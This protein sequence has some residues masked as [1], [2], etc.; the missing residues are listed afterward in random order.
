MT[1]FKEMFIDLLTDNNQK[2]CKIVNK[3]LKVFMNNWINNF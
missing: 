1:M 2:T 3:N